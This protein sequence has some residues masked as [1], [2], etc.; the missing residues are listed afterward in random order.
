MG[1]MIRDITYWQRRWPKADVAKVQKVVKAGQVYMVR[2]DSE[3]K[4][5]YTVGLTEIGS[6]QSS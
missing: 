2:V 3:P 6:Y 5:A 4:I 1:Q